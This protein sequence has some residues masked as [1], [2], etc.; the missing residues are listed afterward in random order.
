MYLKKDKKRNYVWSSPEFK[1]ELNELFAS[2][3]PTSLVKETA[4]GYKT[5]VREYWGEW[6]YCDS[7]GFDYNINEA[8]YCGGCGRK[9]KVVGIAKSPHLFA[10]EYELKDFEENSNG[11]EEEESD[12]ACIGMCASYKT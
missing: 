5:S 1:K 9:I 2:L 8:D 6:I 3:P 11:K 7:C 4:R 10:D 12:I